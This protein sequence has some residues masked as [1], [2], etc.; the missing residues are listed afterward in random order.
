MSNI[1]IDDYIILINNNNKV[2]GEKCLICHMND[3]KDKLIQLGCKHYFHKNCLPKKKIIKCTYCNKKHIF[4]NLSISG[5]C[6]HLI[7]SGKNKGKVCNRTN[8]RY[9]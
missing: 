7:K 2:T 5:K 9:H 8:C 3:S 6:I 1:N 4:K